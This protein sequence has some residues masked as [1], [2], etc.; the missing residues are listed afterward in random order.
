MN[1]DNQI[2]LDCA[3]RYALGRSSYVTSAVS[4]V[5]IECWDAIPSERKMMIVAEINKAIKEDRIGMEMD[6]INW[7]RIVLLSEALL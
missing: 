3:F 4:N 7:Q 5:I 1:L 2:T 6:K